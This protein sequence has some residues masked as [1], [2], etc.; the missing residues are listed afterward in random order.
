VTTTQEA[1]EREGSPQDSLAEKPTRRERSRA[2]SIH[3]TP[4]F[5]PEGSEPSAPEV[6]ERNRLAGLARFQARAQAAAARVTS[7]SSL[8]TARPPSL[9]ESRE[10]HHVAAGHFEAGLIRWPRLAWGY[11]H[12]A[13]KTLLRVIEWVT[14]SP[15]RLAVTLVLIAVLHFW[16]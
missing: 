13:I 6:T 15:P 10:R 8:L 5:P 4:D 7:G 12:L 14:E 9:A 2:S 3:I 16:A 1:A 11:F